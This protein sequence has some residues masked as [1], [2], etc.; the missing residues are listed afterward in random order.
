MLTT[1]TRAPAPPPELAVDE[2]LAETICAIAEGQ[3]AH[4][5]GVPARTLAQCA[6]GLDAA[7]LAAGVTR[8]RA[9]GLAAH[10]GIGVRLTPRG[11]AAAQQI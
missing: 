1:E 4:P 11:R 8:A 5:D 2:D 9:L 6:P 10:I 3:V 7:R